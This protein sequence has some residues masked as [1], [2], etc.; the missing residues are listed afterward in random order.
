[1]RSRL[2]FRQP[3]RG[4]PRHRLLLGTLGL[5]A[6]LNVSGCGNGGEGSNP[7]QDGAPLVPALRTPPPEPEIVADLFPAT[8][9][10]GLVLNHCSTCHSPACAVIGQRSRAEWDAIETSHIPYGGGLSSEDRGKIF[11]YLH[12]HFNDTLPEPE[13]PPRF[14]EPGCRP[15]ADGTRTP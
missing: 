11:D 3:A 14:L 4:Y 9:S 10:R 12:R 15:P 1:M 5:L 2:P 8:A 6:A 7:A 13:V